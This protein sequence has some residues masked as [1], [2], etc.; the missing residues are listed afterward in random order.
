[1]SAVVDCYALHFTMIG[2]PNVLLTNARRASLRRSNVGERRHMI[3]ML[4][5]EN[6]P[7]RY[8]GTLLGS[9]ISVLN[10]ILSPLQR[11]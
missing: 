10:V 9:K 3:L 4:A 6:M 7:T 5:Y 8:A 1:M 11:I 2:P